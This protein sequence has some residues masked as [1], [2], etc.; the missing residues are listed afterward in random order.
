M[1]IL[2]SRRRRWSPR[3]WIVLSTIVLEWASL[4]SC[5]LWH[6]SVD[7]LVSGCRREITY[8]AKKA[9]SL[10]ETYADTYGDFGLPACMNRPRARLVAGGL[11]RWRDSD[12]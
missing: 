12:W 6:K 1:R 3:S 7:G 8:V 9:Q 2:S 10:H 4:L 5:I 11:L